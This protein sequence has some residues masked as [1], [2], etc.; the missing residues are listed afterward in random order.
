MSKAD[1]RRRLRRTRGA[2]PADLVDGWSAAISARLIAFDDWK[3]ASAIHSYVGALPGEV[4]TDRLI[5]RALV[6][7]KRVIS[8]RI[9]PHGQLEHRE[10][11]D[12]SQL[13]ETAFGLREPD[14]EQCPPAASELADLII[15]PGVAFTVD[16]S[17]LGMGGGYYD[18]FLAQHA[19]TRVG[20][21]YEMQLVEALPVAA[22]DQSMDW[23]VT[24]LRVIRCR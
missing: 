17:R 10:L 6:Q 18:L 15:V 3:Q 9:R 23:I 7:R 20:L 11:S 13:G 21:S 12:L 8:P 22:H 4:L 2:L 5:E 16:G 14:P 24:E 19:A 1:L